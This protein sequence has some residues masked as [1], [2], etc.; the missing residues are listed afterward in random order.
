MDGGGAP[1]LAPPYPGAEAKAPEILRL[2]QAYDRA[3]R[4]LLELS[5]GSGELGHAP[6][7]FCVIH[8]VELYL[9]AFRRSRGEDAAS[10]RSSRHDL[11]DPALADA[12]S[13]RVRTRNHLGR[14]SDDREYLRTRYD[15]DSLNNLSELTRLTST[16]NEIASKVAKAICQ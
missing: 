3:A 4:G 12:L 7:R 2:A 1:N 13:L 14:L 15:P 9:N 5:K 10:I 16:L 11:S 8:A 6:A